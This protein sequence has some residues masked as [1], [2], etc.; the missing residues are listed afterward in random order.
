MRQGATSRKVRIP[1]ESDEQRKFVTWFRLQYRGVRI[2]A[3][4]NGGGRSKAQAGIL[5][6]EGVEAGVPDLF[7]P[8]FR[9]FIE[10]K[11]QKGGVLSEVQR[12]WRAYLERLDYTVLVCA[13]FKEA[14]EKVGLEILAR[15]G[16]G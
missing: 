7:C 8:E 12:D 4:P 10:M 2:F 16:L 5:K 3:I 13:G 14:R 11:R 1:T 9:M 15:G 6:A